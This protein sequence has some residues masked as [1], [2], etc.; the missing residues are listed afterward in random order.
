M[1]DPL[2]VAVSTKN[3]FFSLVALFATNFLGWKLFAKN[4]L[5][6]MKDHENRL[7]FLEKNSPGIK[8]LN[9]LGSSVNGKLDSVIKSQEDQSVNL[10]KRIDEMYKIILTLK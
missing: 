9:E 5:E 8:Y 3:L 10:N 4:K 7:R 6:Q 2:T 1:S